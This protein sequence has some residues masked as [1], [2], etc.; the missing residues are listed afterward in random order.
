M[1]VTRQGKGAAIA[2]VLAFAAV[3]GGSV[4]YLFAAGNE[5]WF[6]GVLVMAI[7]GL[8]LS[9][10]AWLLTRGA[11]APPIEV[12]RPALESG[13]VLLYL[14]IYAVLFLGFGFVVDKRAFDDVFGLAF[15]VE[16][17]EREWAIGLT[18]LGG[19][20]LGVG[21]DHVAAE[22]QNRHR[23]APASAVRPVNK[24]VVNL[25]RIILY[26]TLP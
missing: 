25:N 6:T 24:P 23:P 16:F 2:A 15:S 12:K 11:K 18:G 13:A 8:V 3:W 20:R 1:S 17:A 19:G 22:F 5:D 26:A 14:A 10:V 4:Y 7:F 21:H 9:G